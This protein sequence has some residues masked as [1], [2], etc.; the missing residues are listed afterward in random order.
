MLHS[1]FT[2][3]L[4]AG[5]IEV[6]AQFKARPF[7]SADLSRARTE[8]FR[9][10]GFRKPQERALQLVQHRGHPYPMLSSSGAAPA[11]AIVARGAVRDKAAVIV[12]QTS[13][14]ALGAVAPIVTAAAA[15]WQG[16]LQWI[17][18]QYIVVQLTKFVLQPV[19]RFVVDFVKSNWQVRSMGSLARLTF[20]SIVAVFIA[21]APHLEM[22]AM[23]GNEIIYKFSALPVWYQKLF[24]GKLL[25]W[26]IAMHDP[27]NFFLK[28]YNHTRALEIR[29]ERMRELSTRELSTEKAEPSSWRPVPR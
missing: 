4:L 18:Q 13:A 26:R 12:N 29:E 1:V 16:M 20:W 17:S 23:A 9:I 3:V 10:S 27:W 5:S 24:I 28:N 11:G 21:F 19:A 14:A 7:H 25:L 15:V 2:I 22:L 8:P 6:E